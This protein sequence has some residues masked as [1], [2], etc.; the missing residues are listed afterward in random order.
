M[1]D[2][3]PKIDKKR[4][5]D[6]KDSGP[7]EQLRDEGICG[8]VR[9]SLFETNRR[10]GSSLGH[11][12][13][14]EDLSYKT[15]EKPGSSYQCCGRNKERIVI[16]VNIFEMK[17]ADICSCDSCENGNGKE[18]TGCCLQVG[19]DSEPTGM[20]GRCIIHNKQFR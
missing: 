13:N 9:N 4:E 12:A 11:R 7:R 8:R 17:C 15:V 20:S 2:Q 10:E 18:T 5:F 1:I 16:C 19:S 6:R 3:I 14:E